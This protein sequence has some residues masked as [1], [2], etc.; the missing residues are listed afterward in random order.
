[1]TAFNANFATVVNRFFLMMAVIIVAGFTGIWTLAFLGLPIFLTGI[2]GLDLYDK[3][4]P[5]AAKEVKLNT[6][7]KKVAA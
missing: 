5:P 4:V 7:E 6:I 1:M 2:M 3:Y